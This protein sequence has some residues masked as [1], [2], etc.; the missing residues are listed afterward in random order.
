MRKSKLFKSLN[1]TLFFYLSLPFLMLI[2]LGYK[3]SSKLIFLTVCL[4]AIIYLITAILH[5]IKD[6]SLK[7]EIIIEY[8][9]I[10]ILALIILQSSF[11]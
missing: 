6:K 2:V 1:Y 8:F 9:L 7:L 5:H 11:A 10:A 3:F 4:S